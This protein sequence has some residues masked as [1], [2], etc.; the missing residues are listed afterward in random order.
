MICQKKRIKQKMLNPLLKTIQILDLIMVPELGIE[1]RCP[2]ERGILSPFFI[3]S[4]P[5]IYYQIILDIKTTY[6]YITFTTYHTKTSSFMANMGREWG[7][8][9]RGTFIK[10]GQYGRKMD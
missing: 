1:P 4:L 10:R 5:F 9:D 7:E 6:A 2:C 3:L 8:N